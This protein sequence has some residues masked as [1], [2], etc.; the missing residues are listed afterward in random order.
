M[1][2]ISSTEA[3]GVIFDIMTLALAAPAMDIDRVDEGTDA[4]CVGILEAENDFV[5]D[6]GRLGALG[7]AAPLAGGKITRSGL[8]SSLWKSGL[9]RSN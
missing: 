3:V 6:A 9:F 5:I 1:A 2:L 4:G 8:G 7:G